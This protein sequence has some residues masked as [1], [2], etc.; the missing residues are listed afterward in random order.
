MSR[1]DP[2][3]FQAISWCA[4]LLADPDYVVVPSRFGKPAKNTRGDFFTRTLATDDTIR[5]FVY[6][7]RKGNPSN[8]GGIS[9]EAPPQNIVSEV[10]AFLDSRSGVNGWPGIAHGGFVAA[11]IDEVMGFLINSN[12]TA[13][14]TA[15]N[16]PENSSDSKPTQQQLVPMT[17]RGSAVMTAE[18]TTKYRS[19]VPTG[20]PLLVRAWIERVDGRKIFVRAAIEDGDR[21]ILTEG[22]G[23]FLTLKPDVKT[24]RAKRTNSKM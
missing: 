18:L 14:E 16:P 24:P 23:L 11:V 9:A 15:G 7:T 6:Q 22:F 1:S 20:E 19:P 17:T 10:R 4:E 3:Y 13:T 8:A 2:A 12:R 21:N 5:C